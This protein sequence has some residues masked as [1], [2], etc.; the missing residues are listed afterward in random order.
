MVRWLDQ[1]L[2][3]QCWR[4]GKFMRSFFFLL[5]LLRYLILFR[6]SFGAGHRACLGW[7]FACVSVLEL[8]LLWCAHSSDS[9]SRSCKSFYLNSFQGKTARIRRENCLVMLPMVGGEEKKG[10]QL[11]LRIT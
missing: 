3:S 5:F 11:P 1:V 6:M 8:V 9:G 2:R 7:R 4:L 10:N